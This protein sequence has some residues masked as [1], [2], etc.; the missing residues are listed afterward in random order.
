MKAW[1]RALLL[2]LIWNLLT[3]HSL[4]VQWCKQHLIRKHSFWNLPTTGS[5]SWAWRQILHLRNI[6]LCHLVYI[7]GREDKFSLW[8][9][10]WFHGRSISTVYGHRVINDSGIADSVRVQA[11]I[12]NDH[13]CWLATSPDLIEIQYRVQDIPISTSTDRIFWGSV[14]QPFL[15]KKAWELVRESAPPVRWVNLVWHSSRISKHAFCLWLAILGAHRTRDKLLTLGLIHSA[16]CLFNC[17]E[18]ESE[19]HLFFECPYTRQ[20]WSMVLSKCNIRRSVLTWPQEIQWMTDH[21]RGNKFPK[22]LRK[23]ALAA[24]VYHV[25]MERNRRAF[26]NSFLPPTAIVFKIQCDVA[27][28]MVGK[29]INLDRLDEH[30]HSLGISWGITGTV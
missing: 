17:G 13:W 24:T 11:V 6:A 30:Y 1:N 15:T 5:I 16:C 4:W 20:I 28:K 22:V 21:T 19:H 18:N 10:P 14:G 9:D 29:E 26:K 3:E 2:K 7:C 12:A 27:S 23:L 25:W 8:H